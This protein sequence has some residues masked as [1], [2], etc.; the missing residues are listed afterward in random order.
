MY[1]LHPNPNL[2]V[3]NFFKY[4][5]R[6]RCTGDSLTERCNPYPTALPGLVCLS[7][8]IA[9]GNSIY[10]QLL[11][12]LPVALRH[13]RLKR[14][15]SCAKIDGN[16]GIPRAGD[17]VRAGQAGVSFL[18]DPDRLKQPMIRTGKRGEGKFKNAT[19]KEALDYTAEKMLKI[20][21]NM[22]P[23]RSHSLVTPP[24]ISGSRTI[25][26]RHGDR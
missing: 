23:S 26:R 18:Y 22:D 25:C 9:K 16:P 12:H 24:E 13:H 10:I 19:W 20:K 8:G 11:R 3:A 4:C 2:P 21:R 1:E 5:A 14:E 7:R 15:W 6:H 17:V